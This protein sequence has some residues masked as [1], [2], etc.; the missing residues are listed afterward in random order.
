MRMVDLILKK[1]AKK[2]LSR[3]EIEWFIQGFT[4]GEIPDYQVSGLMM[5]VYFQGME[6]EETVDLVQA[7]IDSGDV[8][9]LSGIAGEKV[10]KHSTGGVGDKTSIVLGPMVAACGV[11]VAKLSG[12]GLGHTGGTLDKL[13]S[14]AGFKVELE[15][16]EFIRN[17]NEVGIAIVSQTAN[18]VPADKKLYALRDV[19]GTVENVSLIAGSIMSKK[20]ASG[21]G[22]IVLDVKTGSGAF[23]KTYAEAFGLAKA[24]VEI[25]NRM[26][27]RTVALVSDMNQPLGNMVGNA[28]EIKE[29]IETLKGNGPAD[30]L[31]LCLALG[32]EML[33]A[34]KRVSTVKEGRV[35]LQEA[36]ASGAALEKLKDLVRAQGGDPGQVDSPESLPAAHSSMVVESPRDGFVSGLMADHVGQ[37]SMLLGAGRETKSSQIDLGAGIELKAKVGDAVTAGQPLAILYA[38]DGSRLEAAGQHLLES[39]H[40]SDSPVQPRSLIYG[41]IDH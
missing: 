40:F 26:G 20:L 39:Y 2:A 8:I 16:A 30:L 1:R 17:V 7:M 25:G 13:E 28:M 38:N 5:A 41:K 22:G 21:A 33:V 29:A 11:P 36:I 19:T 9:D 10:D 15:M 35:L 14:F 4:K 31:E 18:L 6:M 3:E 32:A 23:M 37:A 24:M 12:R 34:A 27:R